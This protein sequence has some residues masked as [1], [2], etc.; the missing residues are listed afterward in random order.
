ML[1]VSPIRVG[2]SH[3]FYR[4]VCAFPL[5]H[6]CPRKLEH[7]EFCKQLLRLKQLVINYQGKFV[8]VSEHHQNKAG[9]YILFGIDKLSN[10]PNIGCW[11][12]QRSNQK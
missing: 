7:K 4:P 6:S 2:A 9:R 8:L 5:G 1:V 12:G 3:R 11:Q 10:N